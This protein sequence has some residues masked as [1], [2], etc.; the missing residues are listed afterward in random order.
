MVPNGGNQVEASATRLATI[1]VL[2]SGGHDPDGEHC[3]MEAVAYVANEP[4]TDTPD[5]TCPVI[6]AFL[7]VWND[8][9]PDDQ[10][11]ELLIPLV[12]RV[13]GTR[14]TPAVETT[15]SLMAVDW[16]VRV[17]TPVWLRLAGLAAHADALESLAEI[18]STDQVRSMRTAI[19][20]A[21]RDAAAW[22]DADAVAATACDAGAAGAARAAAAG[23]AARAAASEGGDACEAPERGFVI[24]WAAEEARDAA[25]AAAGAAARDKLEPEVRKLQQS[26]LALVGRM[27]EAQ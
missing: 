2:H 12:P 14:S 6:G 11:S 10:R 25:R 23:D 9:L 21:S 1:K 18:T 27:I 13:I 15:R 5:C 7:R 22:A 24:G 16:L 20:A 8:D 19:V 26:A 17:H 3:V 4:W